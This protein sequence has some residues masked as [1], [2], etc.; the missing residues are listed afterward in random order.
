VEHRQL[1][2]KVLESPPLDVSAIGDKADYLDTLVGVC[3]ALR[4][5]LFGFTGSISAGQ[6]Q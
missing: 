1:K 4:V 5:S 2:D 6:P 3:D